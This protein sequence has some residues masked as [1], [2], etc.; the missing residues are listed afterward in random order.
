MA[1]ET[2]DIRDQQL[3][4]KL[5]ELFTKRYNGKSN[6]VKSDDIIFHLKATGHS[7][8]HGR[9]IRRIIGHIRQNDLVSPS[10][11]LSNVHAGYWLSSDATEMDSYIDQEM[12]RMSS[13]FQNI[14]S[15]HQRIR[16][17]KPKNE[18]QPSLF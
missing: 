9:D 2:L 7:N 16:Y 6:A 15:L 14:K 10:F 1:R 3:T 12:N 13:Q 17:N 18:T 4:D 8:V 5:I 11:I